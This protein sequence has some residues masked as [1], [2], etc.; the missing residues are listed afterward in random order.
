MEMLVVKFFRVAFF[1]LVSIGLVNRANAYNLLDKLHQKLPQGGDFSLI[2]K[3]IGKKISKDPLNIS[4][5]NMNLMPPAS[6]QKLATALAAKLY[7]PQDF[8]FKTKAFK[9]NGDLLLKFSGD[10]TLISADLEKLLTNLVFIKDK[11]NGDIWLDPS[12]FTGYTKAPGWPWENLAIGYSAPVSAITLDKNQVR[13]II[14]GGQK[15]GKTLQI[16]AI[17]SSNL[18]IISSAKTLTQAMIDANPCWLEVDSKPNNFYSFS[19]CLAYR[20]KPLRLSLAIQTPSLYT[21][22]VVRSIIEKIDPKWQG[23]VMVGTPPGDRIFLGEHQS[24]P[25]DKLVKLM[26]KKSKNL[27][28]ESLIKTI[29]HYYYQK[30]GS[31]VNGTAAMR[32]ILLA[33]GLDMQLAHFADGSGL[34]RNNRMN[35]DQLAAVMQFIFNKPELGL[36]KALPI[37]GVDGTLKNYRSAR[38][39]PLLGKLVAKTGSL[40]GARNLVGVMQAS[41][42]QK[43]LLVMLISNC[44]TKPNERHPTFEFEKLL[45]NSIYNWN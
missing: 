6:T 31:F 40:Y 45:F 13:A 26:L 35:A 41:S 29:G 39:K 11:F 37:S 25:L 8:R 19:G 36:A 21:A 9:L 3:P 38:Y 2:V 15:V 16:N 28:A 4:Y 44:F 7:L 30:P 1:L 20:E 43:Y 23:N 10:P 42:G 12:I 27:I 18:T 5:R 24:A 22:K 34:S 14:P 33:Y 17:N 32:Q